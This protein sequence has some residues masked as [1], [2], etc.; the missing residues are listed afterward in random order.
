MIVKTV[1]EMRCAVANT[2]L[3]YNQQDT[4]QPPP[5]APCTL[6]YALTSYSAA[7]WRYL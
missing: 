7:K 1:G 4:L 6:D 3:F 5:T 2:L